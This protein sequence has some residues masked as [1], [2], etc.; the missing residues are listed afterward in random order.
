MKDISY[1]LAFLA[2][3]LSFLSPCVL[4]LLPSYVSF[5]TGLSL[6]DLTVRKDKRAVM[7]ITSKNAL[8]FIFG[9]SFIFISLGVSSS[10]IGSLL[11][12]YLDYIRIIGGILVIIFGLFISGIL[13]VDMFMKEKKYHLSGKPAGYFGTFIVGMTF[14]AGWSPC[15]GPFL[16]TIL[17][18]AGAKGSM[19]YGLKLL[20]VYSLGLAIPFFLFAIGINVFL[21]HSPKIFKYMRVITV[22]SGV[23]LIIFGI[24]LL[25][26]K[27]RV[28]STLL[29]DTVIK[30]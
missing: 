7:Y 27:I 19:I 29:P 5:I 23:V 30:F 14:A 26:D 12:Q 17:V 22:I 11:F 24:L 16:G 6:K 28:L 8:A 20:T 18:Y 4:P 21:T 13:R 9:F 1:P 15:V 3:I 10:A 25:A 2:G